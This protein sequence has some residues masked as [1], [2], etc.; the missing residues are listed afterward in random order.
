MSKRLKQLIAAD[1]KS[2]LDGLEEAV[3]I[4]CGGLAVAET[5]D[6]RTSLRESGVSMNVVKNTLARRVFGDMGYDVPKTWFE[7]PTAVL[8]GEEDAVTTSKAFD[9]WRKKNKKK[10]RIKGGL[11]AGEVLEG[12]EAE[13]LADMPSPAEIKG[14]VVNVVAA[15]LIDFVS[16]TN[17]VL[18]AVPNVLQAIADKKKEEGE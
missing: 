12:A 1:L 8:S 7:G 4:E 3:V 16:V 11:L 6:F 9:D 14:M 13:N 17:N 10:L 18:A 15:P 5:E 2:R